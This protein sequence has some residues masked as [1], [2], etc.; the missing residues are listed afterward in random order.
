MG[1][2]LPQSLSVHFELL[3]PTLW[4]HATLPAKRR[5]NGMKEQRN[6]RRPA[7]EW[8]RFLGNQT[9]RT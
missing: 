1:L 6:I 3:L 9:R 5:D 7:E 8:R 2:I 4:E